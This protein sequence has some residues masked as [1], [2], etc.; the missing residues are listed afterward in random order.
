MVA[1]ADGYS[2][3]STHVATGTGGAGMPAVTVGQQL[4]VLVQEFNS[5]FSTCSVA[6][7]LGNVYNPIDSVDYTT[8][9]YGFWRFQCTV[10]NPGT[11]VITA[12]IPI[13]PV[14]MN[15]AVAVLTGIST[16]NPFTSGQVAHNNQSPLVASTNNQTSGLV[17]ATGNLASEPCTIAGWGFTIHLANAPTAGSGFTSQGTLWSS[18]GS[19]CLS[20]ET[21]ALTSTT[22][23]AATFTP[24]STAR[25]FT[26]AAVFNASSAQLATSAQAVAS[27]PNSLLTLP[28]FALIPLLPNL[29]PPNTNNSYS[30][31][32]AGL[33]VINPIVNMMNQGRLNF[34]ASV[35]YSLTATT[36]SPS[37]AGDQPGQTN[38]YIIT[39]TSAGYV[40]QG[41]ITGGSSVTQDGFTR[42]I[43]NGSAT[44]SFSLGHEVSGTAANQFLLPNAVP[45]VIAPY[46]SV[47][48]S[49]NVTLGGSI[50]VGYCWPLT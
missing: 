31:D 24:I 41:L 32:T 39:P 9:S 34:S 2:S 25:G 18:L 14:S 49:F 37:I 17:P 8:N 50:V 43:V 29:T 45:L 35:S 22:A 15:I 21:E 13:Y 46:G 26:F 12:S 47:L 44:N 4:D 20:Y 28:G 33:L 19:A 11:P 5:T 40:L 42:Q 30:L 27:A 38:R 1:L 16:S 36:D 6:D 10:T 7:S 23:V 3:G 48:V